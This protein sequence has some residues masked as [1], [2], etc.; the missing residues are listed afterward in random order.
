MDVTTLQTIAGMMILPIL[1]ADLSLL[2]V[3]ISVLL[4]GT[5]PQYS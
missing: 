4:F 2:M 1:G 3:N 5:V